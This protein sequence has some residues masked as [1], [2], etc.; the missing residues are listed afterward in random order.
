[1]GIAMKWNM[2]YKIYGVQG[3]KTCDDKW[4]E[5]YH[6]CNTKMSSVSERGGPP[7][8]NLEAIATNEVKTAA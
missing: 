3:N 4:N 2:W 6:K 5:I 7:W 8:I 1:M